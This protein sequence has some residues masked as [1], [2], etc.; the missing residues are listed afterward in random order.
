VLAS[1]DQSGPFIKLGP[2]ASW[3]SF[4]TK[5]QRATTIQN[6]TANYFKVQ[7]L[8]ANGAVLATSAAAAGP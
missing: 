8:G 1:H 3:S 2:P 4:E 5:I 6:A 7:A